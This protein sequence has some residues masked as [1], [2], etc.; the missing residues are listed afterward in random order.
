M[1]FKIPQDVQME[2]KIVGPLT[3]KQLL[4]V[5]VGGGLDYVLYVSLS[6]VYVLTVWI[7][8]VV[9]IALLTL[10]IAFIKIQSIPFMRYILLS[11]EYYLKPRKRLWVGGGGEV[12]I[13]ITQPEPKTKAQLAQDKQQKKTVPKN[14]DNLDEL[15]RILDSHTQ[16]IDTKHEALQK[17]IQQPPKTS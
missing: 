13:S 1:Q 17:I 3:L 9:I 2:D 4:I 11:M 8:P 6:K 14:L 15:T 10:A 16:F 12:F 7:L 5:A